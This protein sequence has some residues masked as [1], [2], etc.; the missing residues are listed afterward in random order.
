MNPYDFVP[1][2]WTKP[3][4]RHKPQY[5]DRFDG[6]CGYIQGTITA[7]TPLFIPQARVGLGGA[8]TAMKTF[9]TNKD[10]NY[11]IPGSSLKGLC[12]SLVETMANGCFFLFDGEYRDRVNYTQKIPRD[13]EKC[14]QFER[15]CI[16]CRTF[17][18][19]QKSN[20]FQGKVSFD[21]AFCQN[22]VEHIPIYTGILDTPKPRHEAFYLDRN[23][24]YIAGRK[25]Y[26]HSPGYISTERELKI[27]RQGIVLNQFIKPLNQG[28]VFSFTMHFNNLEEEEFKALLYALVLEPNMCHKMG[29]AKPIGL[30]S[31]KFELKKVVLVDHVRRYTER[32]LGITEYSHSIS[33]LSDYLNEQLQPFI[34]NTSPTLQALRRIWRWNPENPTRYRYPGQEWFKNNRGA[35]IRESG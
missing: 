14:Y 5:H 13:F 11:I 24:K 15:L 8:A 22:A 27:S 26:F 9:I 10:G 1:V 4:E 17:G 16:A 12:R 31:V 23:K 32:D 30:G 20:L 35:S 29:Y 3:P 7:Y 6:K 21:D 19:I 18:T 2:D 33:N 28:T 34:L 25:F